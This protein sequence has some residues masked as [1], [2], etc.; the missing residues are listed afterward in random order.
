[1]IAADWLAVAVYY[2]IGLVVCDLLH[3]KP[4]RPDRSRPWEAV[5]YRAFFWP[6]ELVIPLYLLVRWL[7]S[8][9]EDAL[10]AC[11]DWFGERRKR[12]DASRP[13]TF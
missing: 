8:H 3:E 7:G 1:M 12:R 2:L 10:Y 11:A 9:I 13:S 6:I 5:A 4:H